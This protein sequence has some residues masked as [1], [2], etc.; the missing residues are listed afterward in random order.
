M[1]L[2]LYQRDDCHLCDLALAVLAQAR[3]PEFDSVFID[4][5]EALEAAYG[6][7]VPVLR[8]AGGRELDWP[9]DS[10]VLTGWLPPH[11]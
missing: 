3:V 7:R 4:D 5:D 8:D 6:T 10:A 2:T 9:F 1:G 11:L